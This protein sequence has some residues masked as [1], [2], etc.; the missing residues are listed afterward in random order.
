MLLIF[1]CP[2]LTPFGNVS[3]F[4]TE[5]LFEVHV[6]QIVLLAILAFSMR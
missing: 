6:L 2:Y 4:I 5:F 1:T 3:N